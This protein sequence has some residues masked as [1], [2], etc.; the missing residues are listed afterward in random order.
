MTTGAETIVETKEKN[1]WDLYGPAQ[2]RTFL[3]I[4]F[5]TGTANYADRNVIGVLL[6]PIKAEFGVSDT[7]LGLLTGIAFA[8]FYV[9]LGLPIAWLADR[10]NRRRVITWSIVVWSLMTVM[11]GM[12][13]NFWQLALARMG[14][15]AGEA[16]A[17][18]PAQSLI[19]DYYPPKERAGALG[20]YMMSSMAGYIIGM[21]VGG[22]A[23]QYYGWRA[24]FILVGLPGVLLALATKFLLREP[25]LQAGFAVTPEKTEPMRQGIRLLFAKP[26]YRNIVYAL[27]LYFLMAY[28]ALV[29]MASF[30]IRV[31]GLTVAEAGSLF[32]VMSAA[33]AVIGSLGG[34]KLADRLAQRDIAWVARLPGVGLI[35]AFPLYIAC[36]HSGSL[37]MMVLFAFL[38]GI[39]LAGVVPV[40][41]AAMHVVCGSARRAMAVAIAFFFANLIG[42]GCGPL[43][44]GALSDHMA[45]IYGPAEGLRYALMM[46]TMTFLPAGWFMFRAARYLRA[47]AED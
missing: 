14:V 43:I 24:A 45:Q 20:F 8:V 22:W 13:Q 18:P 15:G 34:G 23:A 1:T 10:G 41:F 16:G 46:T 4:L 37:F 47:D 29:F 27:I 21:V 28:G 2:R 11:C 17:V 39:L 40:I 32:G 25:R 6:E 42:L 31:H 36:F 12:A 7:M 9:T 19:A 5:L 35:L 30:M 3:F 33:T 44:A 26:A 38:G